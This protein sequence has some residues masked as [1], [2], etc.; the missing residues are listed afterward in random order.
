M[1]DPRSQRTGG[2]AGDAA[3]TSAINPGGK[4]TCVNRNFAACQGEAPA[5]PH[6]R[7]ARLIP[8]A[9]LSKM[10]SKSRDD[11]RIYKLGSLPL[12]RAWGK[13]GQAQ[14]T[15]D[16]DRNLS[17]RSLPCSEVELACRSRARSVTF[18]QG[19]STLR[20][21]RPRRTRLISGTD[22]VQAPSLL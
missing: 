2:S 1:G 11:R 16:V 5:E 9:V 3:R 14:A 22:T 21:A 18:D 20:G 13:F 6:S 17:R 12:P 15:I 8:F 19:L 4:K 10:Y 7:Q